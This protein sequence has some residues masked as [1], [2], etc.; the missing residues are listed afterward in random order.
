[1]RHIPSCVRSSQI[2]V[3]CFFPE[4][5]SRRIPSQSGL[6]INLIIRPRTVYPVALVAQFVTSKPSD[7]W[8]YDLGDVTRSGVSSQIMPTSGERPYLD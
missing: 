4:R 2:F 6:V 1:M 8:D 7:G 3:S 5:V